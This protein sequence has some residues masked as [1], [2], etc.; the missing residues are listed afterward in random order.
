MSDIHG[1]HR[2]T[3]A[4]AAYID[5]DDKEI[6][7]GDD[8]RVNLWDE[9][10]NESFIEVFVHGVSKYFPFGCCSS[11]GRFCSKRFNK[12]EDLGDEE[13]YDAANILTTKY[14]LLCVLFTLSNH[15]KKWYVIQMLMLCKAF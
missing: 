15:F 7:K 13:I 11:A 6:N 8:I 5:D 9:S 3:G 2:V 14:D 10:I 4:N 1:Q 12:I